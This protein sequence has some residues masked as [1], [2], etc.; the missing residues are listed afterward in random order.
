MRSAMAIRTS[1]IKPAR[2]RGLAIG[3]AAALLAAAPAWVSPALGY[4]AGSTFDTAAHAA[5]GSGTPQLSTPIV[6]HEPYAYELRGVGCFSVKYCL[7]VGY[8]DGTFTGGVAIPIK[9]GVPGKAILSSNAAS[10]FNAVAC[11]STSECIIAGGQPAE[12][13][14]TDQA[15]VWL[16]QGTKLTL[17]PQ[18][19]DTDNVTAQFL[20]ATC[21]S[22]TCELVGDATYLTNTKAE[23]PIGLFGELTLR[24]SPSVDVVDNDAL[25]YASSVSCPPGPVCFVGGATVT[26]LGAEGY[27]SVSGRSRGDIEGP[28]AQSSV[29]GIDGLAC[30]SYIACGA[31]E[32][33][34]LSTF[35]Q[36]AGWV[37]RLNQHS[38]GTPVPVPGAQLMFGV[39]VLNLSYYL[40]VGSSNGNEWLADLVTAAG[41]PVRATIAAHAGYLQAVSC[42]VQTECVAVG[43]TNDPSSK[44]PGGKSGV[45]GAIALYRIKTAPSAPGLKVT[46][47]T[48]SSLT[49]RITPPG[50]DGGV[51]I[52]SYD[53]VVTRCE[54]H[55][56]G[57]KQELV[58]TLKLAASKH[59]ISVRHLAAST[60]Y[61]AEVRAVN[62]IGAGPYS[63]RVRGRT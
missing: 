42:P 31:A 13:Q 19:T 49:M 45:D 63:G 32:V 36:Y 21:V 9:N 18:S 35:G 3:A 50:S 6:T 17:L 43:F 26:G 44:Q 5:A 12:G 48:S 37:E 24:G 57:C 1:R 23:E 38:D 55:H 27:I 7:A 40:A 46:G 52:K 51:A 47:R 39:A 10:T 4:A 28:F 14:T 54:P 34:N 56:S 60:T 22:R 62:A 25:G 2:R 61:Y 11:V 16:L 33:E 58:A 59:S 8:G 15:V 29:S 41:K 30:Q 53:L 20:G